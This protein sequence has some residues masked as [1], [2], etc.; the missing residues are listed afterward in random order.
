LQHIPSL[1]TVRGNDDFIS[2]LSQGGLQQ[3]P[4]NN[5]IVGDQDT[6]IVIGLG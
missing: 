5:A 4:G 3:V 2:P 1:R 6:H